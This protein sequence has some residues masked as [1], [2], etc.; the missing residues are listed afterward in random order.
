M[1][2]NI[3]NQGTKEH[4]HGKLSRT[5]SITMVDKVWVHCISDKKQY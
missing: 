5:N 2:D 1:D 3:I 4:W